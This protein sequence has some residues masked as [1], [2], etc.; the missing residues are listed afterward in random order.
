MD[1]S[2]DSGTEGDKEAVDVHFD[3]TSTLRFTL[4]LML[5]LPGLNAFGEYNIASQSSIAFGVGL[6]F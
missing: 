1:V 2:Y 4:G 6:G 3:K 5:N